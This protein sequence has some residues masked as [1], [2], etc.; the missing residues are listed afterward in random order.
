MDLTAE[1]INQIQRLECITQ[2]FIAVNNDYFDGLIPL[3]TFRLNTRMIRAGRVSPRKNVMDISIKYHNYYGW[4][5]ELVNT[6]KHECIHLYLYHLQEYPG[7]TPAFKAH[8]KR[9]GASY[10]C[11]SLFPLRKRARISIMR[12]PR[13]LDFMMTS[14]ENSHGLVCLRW[15]Q[16]LRGLQQAYPRHTLSYLDHDD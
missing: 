8:C 1:Q 7:H 16:A 6:I 12:C 9:I 13:C 5:D 14:A 3:P 15:I 11:Q 10:H 2:H 4:T